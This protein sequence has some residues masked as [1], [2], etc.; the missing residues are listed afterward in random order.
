MLCILAL[1][2]MNNAKYVSKC[3]TLKLLFWLLHSHTHST[4]S[5]SV[6][7]RFLDSGGVFDMFV[8]HLQNF[9]SGVLSE[10]DL[11]RTCG[12]LLSEDAELLQVRFQSVRRTGSYH[13]QCYNIQINYS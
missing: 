10:G 9:A 11:A 1:P 8:H 7:R 5:V 3:T 6:R 2:L 13:F 12:A 4:H